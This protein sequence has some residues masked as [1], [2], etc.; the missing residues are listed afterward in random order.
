MSAADPGGG[1][2]EAGSRASVTIMP[3]SPAPSTPDTPP[4]IFLSSSKQPTHGGGM[5]PSPGS[6]LVTIM[7]ADASQTTAKVRTFA[8]H[9]Q[10]V[11]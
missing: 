10:S 4:T 6:P 11:T 1:P 5:V 8:R 7:H 3:C 9:I 2:R